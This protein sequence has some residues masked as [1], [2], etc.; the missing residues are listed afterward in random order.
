M[1]HQ[2]AVRDA[3]ESGLRRVVGVVAAILPLAALTQVLANARDY[4]EPAVAAGVWLAMFVAAV[5]V[6]PWLRALTRTEAVAAV[7]VSAAAVATIGLDHRAYYPAGRVDLSILGTVWLLAVVAL[8]Y[9][10][11]AWITGALSVYAVYAVLLI[12]TVGANSLSLARLE[13]A[14]YILVGILVVFATFRPTLAL[15]ADMAARRAALASRSTAERAA[16][17]AVGEER[18]SRLALLEMEALPLLRGIADGTLDPRAGAV[19]DRCARHATVLRDSL[20][21]HAPGSGELMAWLQPALRHA[22]DRGLLVNVQ[23]IGDPGLPPDE[24]ARAVLAA[25]ESVISALPPHQ[26]TLTVIDSPDGVE[27][28]LT[29]SE[30]LRAI[31]DAARLGPAAVSAGCLEISWRNAGAA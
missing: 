12:R 16:A 1:S 25:V 21:D 13:A 8:S 6:V 23:V 20:T 4:R 17:A 27:L 26:V 11:W 9:P 31:P 29:F 5:C 18:R 14:G 2:E 3:T 24:S 19:R 22:S 10:A 30:P 7:L 28:Y 15:H